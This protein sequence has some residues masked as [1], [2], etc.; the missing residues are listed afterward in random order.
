MAAPSF[1][2]GNPVIDI[3]YIIL[4]GISEVPLISAPL[5]GALILIGTLI[6]SRKAALIMVVSGLIGAGVALLLGASLDLVTFGL[7]GFNSVLT[8]MAFWSGPFTKA[9]KATFFLS[10]FGAAVTAVAWMVFSHV[11]GDW[12]SGLGKGY[13]IPGFTAAFIFTTWVMMWAT[14]RYGIDI[15][16]RPAL[17]EKP[18]TLLEAHHLASGAGDLLPG[19]E[20]PVQQP[21]A[22]FRWNAKEFGIAVLNG[23]SQ[24]TFIENWKTGIFWVVGLTLSFELVGSRL[25]TNAFTTGWD[26]A[27]PLFL[28]GLMALVGSAIGAICAILAKFPVA[29]V[30]AGIHGYNQVLVMIALTSFLPFTGQAFLY[31]VFAT[32]VCSLFT[33]PAMQNFFGR[34][35]IPALTG[36][37]VFTAWFFLLA[38]P[39]AMNIPAGIGWG[40]P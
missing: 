18:A 2:T 17:P 40:R 37:F 7:F 36:P 6:A 16:P 30:R 38:A 8:G 14:K 19:S 25:F 21:D 11:M 10:V 24:V 20:N 26:P 13:A 33:M 27:S 31:A 34:W 28:A 1:S 23:V 32:I 22:A 9:N 3:I 35:G 4:N 12:F 5:A 29:E 39:L 15:W